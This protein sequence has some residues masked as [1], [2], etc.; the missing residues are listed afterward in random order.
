T[1]R[2]NRPVELAT[3]VE[4]QAKLSKRKK[5]SYGKGLHVCDSLTLDGR[6]S[7]RVSPSVGT[8]VPQSQGKC[9]T[10]KRRPQMYDILIKNGTVVYG[11]GS[12]R[13]RPGIAVR[14]GK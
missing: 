1:F 4:E 7:D 13:Y 10:G 8:C 3:I 12:P 6:T 5:V 14:G 2:L 9:P 11:T